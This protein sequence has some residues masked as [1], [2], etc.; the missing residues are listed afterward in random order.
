MTLV[1]SQL[2]V[3]VLVTS[4]CMIVLFK[5]WETT[6]LIL[7]RSVP[8][9]RAGLIAGCLFGLLGHRNADHAARSVSD[10]KCIFEDFKATTV[11]GSRVQESSIL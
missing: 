7:R 10:P 3:A 6:K 5:Y 9:N 8:R 1:D 4:N 11:Y 2:P